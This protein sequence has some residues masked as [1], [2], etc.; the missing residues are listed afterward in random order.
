VETPDKG[1]KVADVF[2]AFETRFGRFSA[3]D[4]ALLGPDK[5]VMFLQAIDI[6]DRKDLGLLLEDTTTESGLTKTWETVRDIVVQYTKRGRWL[7]N[8]GKKIPE[9]TP[10]SRAGS[11][12]QQSQARETT[13][14]RRIEAS[15]ME[16]LLKDMENLKIASVKKS[17]DRSKYMNR[18]C[19]WCD[20]AEH[21]QRDCDE[22]KEALR[23]DLIYYEGNRIHLMDTQK[24]L[25][26]KYRKGGMK[27]VFEEEMAAKNDYAATAG[28]RI[29]EYAE[30]KTSFWP[31]A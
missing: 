1:L 17:E 7:A 6:Q 24:P 12:E 19:M 16:Q 23:R 4:Q 28:I 21:N 27:K 5:V 11:E 9:P 20:S 3:R 26:T 18:R 2:S 31:V 29:R 25:R 10:K 15:A 14:E 8:E 22:R 30:A 13:A